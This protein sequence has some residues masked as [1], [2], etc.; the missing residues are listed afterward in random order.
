MTFSPSAE[1]R[2]RGVVHERFFDRPDE[3]W[4]VGGDAHV[5]GPPVDAGNPRRHDRPRGREIL[6]E[7]QRMHALTVCAF[8]MRHEA[9]VESRQKIGR[10][11]FFDVGHP[12]D[13]APRAQRLQPVARVRSGRR[14]DQQLPLG[15]GGGDMLEDGDARPRR[16]PPEIADLDHP[17]SRA[18]RSEESGI[19][20]IREVMGVAVEAGEDLPVV[21]TGSIVLAASLACGAFLRLDDRPTPPRP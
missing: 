3:A 2:A 11:R 12:H 15:P 14:G 13:V 4:A 7:L 16:H 21:L 8:N 5:L 17:P 20:R 6:Q 9:N 10:R 19:D 1:S 18:G